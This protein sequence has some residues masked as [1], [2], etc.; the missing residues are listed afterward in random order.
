MS[1][2]GRKSITVPAGVE[3]K[4]DGNQV[5]VKGPKGTITRCVPA[6]ISMN[7][8]KGVLVASRPSDEKIHRCA[9]GLTRTL[10]DNMV[11]GVSKGFQ[12]NLE[13]VG[14]GYRAQAAEGKL[15]LYLGFAQPLEFVAPAGISLTVATNT[16]I[17]VSGIDN[18]LVGMVAAQIRELRP[19]DHYKGKGVRYAGERVRLKAGKAGKVGA[20]K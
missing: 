19:P 11:Q 14:V 13:I 15:M 16:K 10:V 5:T 8:D 3:I 12:K 4:I 20:K 9:H 7:L 6:E 18:E 2:V 17:T 1:R